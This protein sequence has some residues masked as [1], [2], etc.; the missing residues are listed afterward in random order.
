MSAVHKPLIVS[1]E[2][3]QGLR[4]IA[5]KSIQGDEA[6][7]KLGELLQAAVR[8]EFA[9]IPPY[10]SAA[11]S[12]KNGANE[13]VRS[14]IMR[15]AKEEMLHMTVVANLM[16]AIGVSPNIVA[17]VP[18]YPHN[19]DVIAPPLRLDLHSFSKDVVKDL[20]MRIETPEDPQDFP[21]V[22][23][24][25]SMEDLPQTIGQFYENIIE[26][27]RNDVIGDLFSQAEQDVYKQIQ[28]VIQFEAVAYLNDQDVQTYPLQDDFD[29]V[30]RDKADAIKYLTWVVHEG[31]GESPF[32][33]LD[34]EGLPGHYYRFESIVHGRYLIKDDTQALGYSYSGGM[35]PFDESGV[36]QFV[37]NAKAEDF[38]SFQTVQRHMQ[39]FN[40]TYTELVDFLH[41]A[42][43]CTSPDNE[44]E[45]KQAYD[46]S[47][48]KMRE[49]IGKAT[50]V[51]RAAETAG[52]KAGL[53]FQ[54]TPT[55][56][57][58]AIPANVA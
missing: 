4:S 46:D 49:M 19:L 22:S 6:R 43:N 8:L 57:T 37:D 21:V 45:A 31:E 36:Y 39:R 33:P 12:L 58:S 56:S 48:G 26:L 47:I 44:A 34:A 53:P 52:I 11:L 2:L 25:E 27:I 10:L 15:I 28:V 55:N 54:Y 5:T 35:L 7:T 18:S 32:N 23:A 38:S 1:P 50:A 29:F 14:L 20:F 40:N 51:I 41:K 42:F 3:V 13:A 24:L 17:A 9:T 16:N 30:I